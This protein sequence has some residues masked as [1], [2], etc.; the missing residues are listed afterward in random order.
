MSF[1]EK[2]EVSAHHYARVK[3]CR[4]ILCGICNPVSSST[5]FLQFDLIYALLKM[6]PVTCISYVVF[7]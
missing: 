3:T 5:N 7:M 2:P 1:V 6:F 4:C